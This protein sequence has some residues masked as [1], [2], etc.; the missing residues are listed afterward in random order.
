MPKLDFN[1]TNRCNFRCRHCCFASG[2]VMLNEFSL[3]KI[4]D[5]LA[6]FITLGGQRIDITGGEPTLRQDYLEIIDYAKKIGLKVE[7]VTNGSL[8]SE[9]QLKK[10]R[11]IGLD[12]IAVSLDGSNYEIYKKTRPVDRMVYERI[13]YNIKLIIQHGFYLKINT[14]VRNSNLLDLV[15]INDLAIKVGASEHGFY[16]FTPVGRGGDDC[17]EVVDPLVWLD[18]VRDKLVSRQKYIKLSLETALVENNLCGNNQTECYLKNPWHLQILPDGN[19]Y[20]CAIMAAIG[21][22]IGNLF[23]SSLTDIWQDKRLWDGSYYKKNVLLLIE[24]YGTCVNFGQNFKQVLMRGYKP[25]CLMCKYKT[26]ELIREKPSS[27]ASV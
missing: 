24:R 8:I 13:I 23:D 11:V 4:K 1:I 10:L 2:E 15:K 22:S 26:K 7:L 20:P 3:E 27:M 5:I 9:G 25:V 19:V 18:L 16:Y 17:R 12:A 21:A 14:V 6:E